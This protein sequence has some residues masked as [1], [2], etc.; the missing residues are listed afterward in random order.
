MRNPTLVS[1]PILE[2]QPSP[3]YDWVWA[4]LLSR[5]PIWRPQ[6]KPRRP[7]TLLANY[8]QFL[9]FRLI[10]VNFSC[11]ESEEGLDGT[12]LQLCQ[13]YNPDGSLW[14]RIVRRLDF[15]LELLFNFLLNWI[16]RRDQKFSWCRHNVKKKFS[17]FNDSLYR[18]ASSCPF[19]L[20]KK[21]RVK[22]HISFKF[23][24]KKV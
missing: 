13:K 17:L 3:L 24:K 7:G 10:K 12:S 1:E 9:F 21:N 22:V 16:P 14:T 11:D 15:S 20:K 4:A 23:F 19:F 6:G 5:G 8:G 18:L 2:I